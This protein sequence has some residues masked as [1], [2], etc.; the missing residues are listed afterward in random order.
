MKLILF[1]FIFL[2]FSLATLWILIQAEP[3][4]VVCLVSNDGEKFE[5]DSKIISISELVMGMISGKLFD[6]FCHS[7]HS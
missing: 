5:V 4:K 1:I 2:A 7:T 6:L 3:G